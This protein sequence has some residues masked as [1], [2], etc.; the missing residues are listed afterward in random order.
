MHATSIML[1]AS[2]ALTALAAGC[3]IPQE[4]ADNG[5]NNLSW[6]IDVKMPDCSSRSTAN[7]TYCHPELLDGTR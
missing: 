4:V 2:L 1:I 7:N 3:T 5:G 6:D